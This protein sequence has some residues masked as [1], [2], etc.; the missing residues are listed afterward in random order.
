MVA[1]N[2]P[3]FEPVQADQSA[4][5]QNRRTSPDK[6]SGENFPDVMSA[7]SDCE[8]K[9]AQVKDADDHVGPA[10]EKAAAGTE[11][12]PD[13]DAA[14]GVAG[15]QE[16]RPVQGLRLF[17]NPALLAAGF[18]LEA[19]PGKDNKDNQVINM[20]IVQAGD[21]PSAPAA[22]NSGEKMG[23][24]SSLPG[25]KEES[26]DG[27]KDD[28]AQA[29]YNIT[30]GMLPSMLNRVQ[31]PFA[32]ETVKF[33]PV[34]EAGTQRLG[35]EDKK[36][37]KGEAAIDASG[38]RFMNAVIP[39]EKP[40]YSGPSAGAKNAPEAAAFPQEKDESNQ[41]IQAPSAQKAEDQDTDE[42]HEAAAEVKSPDIERPE[43]DEK[44]ARAQAGIAAPVE[45]PDKG[46]KT[47]WHASI[48]GQGKNSGVD[49]GA[50]AKVADGAGPKDNAAR[51]PV[52]ADHIPVRIRAAQ[53]P[54]GSF[55]KPAGDYGL[56]IEA[57]DN[58]KAVPGAGGAAS[59][60][61]DG[62]G[63]NGDAGD[64]GNG[65]GPGGGAGMAAS[66][67]SNQGVVNK[68]Y[69]ASDASAG[70]KTP[71][72][73]KAQVFEKLDYGVRMSLAQGG[74]EMRIS[75][76]PGHLGSLN[77][78]VNVADGF[79]KADI[80]VD[81]QAIKMVL[82]GDS[83]RLKEI[84]TRSGLVLERY[85]VTVNPD[86]SSMNNG[87]GS[88]GGGLWGSFKEDA[89]ARNLPESSGAVGRQAGVL[90]Q[91]QDVIGNRPSGVDIF[92]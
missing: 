88:S 39:D 19:E 2:I 23:K 12:A 10:A 44:D 37:T 13:A 33:Q 78:K 70:V 63:A 1:M 38:A 21:S 29:A 83:S 5:M 66:G 82:D 51:R 28:G 30:S 79:V 47:D 40:G 89:R 65:A 41:A 9:P 69:D 68:T 22:M 74:K 90:R 24:A 15:L 91:E 62:S 32:G 87:S 53:G 52:E 84:F 77:I 92:A 57:T 34:I 59:F 16:E 25:D 6:P 27:I 72:H 18:R 80:M 86:A 20:E 7:C 11:I 17:P 49:A 48:A 54:A 73:E 31:P 81:S 71:A 43:G 45:R 76:H 56:K 4:T 50:G 61:A 55:L 67:A 14:K 60:T 46:I 3:I 64:K 58:E 35:I 26:G 36:D 42:R 75:L 85:S 8:G